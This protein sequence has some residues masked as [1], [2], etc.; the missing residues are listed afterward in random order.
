MG[1]ENTRVVAGRGLSGAAAA[2]AA[3]GT[4]TQTAGHPQGAQRGRVSVAF[5]PDGKT[6]ASGS[7]DKTIKLWDVATGKEQATLKGHTDAV[8]SVAFS[9]DG[10]TLAS[11]SEDKTIKLWDV[12]TG[13]EQATLKGHTRGVVRG[14]QPGR[15]DAGLGERGQDDQAVGRGDGQGTGHPQGTHGQGVRPWRSA[16]TA[17]RWPRGAMDKT[18]KLWDVATGKEQ[19]TLKGHTDAV[20]SVAFSPDG[21]TLASGEQR[22]DDQAVGRGD[23]QGTGH[24]Q[25]THGRGVRPWRYSP[26]GKTLASG[27]EDQTIKLWDVATGKEQATLKGHTDC[28]VRP[29]RSVRT[30][31]RWPRGARTRRSSCGTWRRAS[32]RTSESEPVTCVPRKSSPTRQ[33]EPPSRTAHRQRRTEAMAR[34]KPKTYDRPVQ[35][36]R[37]P[38]HQ[39][40]S[41]HQGQRPDR[42]RPQAQA[43][44]AAARRATS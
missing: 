11:G 43:R 44:P 31:R 12:A 32:R 14:V 21:K 22:Q 10:K 24:P 3:V 19:A 4:G 41:G 25:G 15:Q 13:K 1:R 38:G 27:S 16:R 33:A 29:W 34:K 37:P 30:A 5:S 35:R 18:I 8:S 36:P 28:G 9:P 2:V 7:E 42:E 23:G 20:C 17:R 6:L 39:G 40:R 26:D